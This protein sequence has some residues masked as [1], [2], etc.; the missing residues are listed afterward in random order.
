MMFELIDLILVGIFGFAVGAL[1]MLFYFV[2]E[3]KKQEEE[4]EGSEPPAPFDE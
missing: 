4:E 2:N 3:E 1:V